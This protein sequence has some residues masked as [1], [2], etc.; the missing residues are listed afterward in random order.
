M[1]V[2][3]RTCYYKTKYERPERY[4]FEVAR[5]RANLKDMVF[6]ISPADVVVPSHCPLLGI[7]LVPSENKISPGSPSLD[8]K[9]SM[10]G[11]VPGNV[12]VISHQAN[13]MKSNATSAELLRFATSVL[14]IHERETKGCDSA[15]GSGKSDGSSDDAYAEQNPTP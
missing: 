4:L 3:G 8:R 15:S 10:K 7:P 5:K 6:T 11:Y 12:W 13:R 9:D 1:S 14:E 2:K